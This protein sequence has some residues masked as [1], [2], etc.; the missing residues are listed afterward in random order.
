VPRPGGSALSSPICLVRITEGG[1]GAFRGYLT[2]RR[3]PLFY[4]DPPLL[5]GLGIVS[6]FL[7]RKGRDFGSRAT[8]VSHLPCLPPHP[9]VPDWL[10]FS[11]SPFFHHYVLGT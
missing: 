1:P 2:L 7:T 9:Q 3:A 8:E 6:P 5:T 11:L 4:S 10:M